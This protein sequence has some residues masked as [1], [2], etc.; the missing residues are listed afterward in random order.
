MKT[1]IGIFFDLRNPNWCQRPWAQHY[2]D[3][4]DVIDLA[5]VVGLDSI[6]LSEHHLFEDGYL[7]QPLVLAAAIAASAFVIFALFS[8][9]IIWLTE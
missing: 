2:A 7:S 4:L 9:L 3:S 5:E 8:F 6:W 1:K